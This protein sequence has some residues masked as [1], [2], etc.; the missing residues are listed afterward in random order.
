MIAQ[1]Q[2][3]PHT[4]TIMSSATQYTAKQKAQGPNA[5]FRTRGYQSMDAHPKRGIDTKRNEPPFDEADFKRK[6]GRIT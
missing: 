3:L 6:Y 2:S 4:F 5:V 1:N